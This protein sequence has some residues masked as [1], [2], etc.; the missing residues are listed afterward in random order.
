MPNARTFAAICLLGLAVAGPA[1]AQGP[2]APKPGPEHERLGLFVGSWTSEGEMKASPL[3]PGGKMTGTDRCEWFE[4][5]FAVVCH[6]EGKGPMGQVKGLGIMSYSPEEKLF[7]YYGTDSSGMTMATV[8]KG[9]VQG[10]TWT[11]SDESKMG[12]KTIKGRYTIK[13]LSPT[14]YTFK[15]EMQG[16]SGQW[17]SVAEGK[18]TKTQ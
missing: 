9:T 12:G 5:K 2:Q 10:D 16:D 11:Y 6:N 18:S 8:A 4:G 1:L 14:S 3:G 7:T 15:W 17:M 13:V